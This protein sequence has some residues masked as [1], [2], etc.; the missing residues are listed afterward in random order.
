MGSDDKGWSAL[1]MLLADRKE[2]WWVAVMGVGLDP[3]LSKVVCVLGSGYCRS[4][5]R[6]VGKE[7]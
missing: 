1:V 5:E 3:E 4:E 6:R 7:C 2:K